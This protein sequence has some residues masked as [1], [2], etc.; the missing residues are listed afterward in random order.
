[1]NDY[2]AIRILSAGAPITGVRKCA[3]TH[4]AAT[5]QRFEIERA[6]APVL[7]ERINSETGVADII[8]APLVAM[9]KFVSAGRVD[10]ATVHAIGSVTIGV[11]VRNG[12]PEPDL[13]SLES[14]VHNVLAAD[15]VVYNVASS[16]QYVARMFAD[17]GLTD[18]IAAKTIIVP[19][20][21][22]VMQRLVENATSN[23]IGF[24]HITEIR[25]HDELGTHLVGQLPMAIGR[26]TPYAVGII[27]TASAVSGARALV[28]FMGSEEGHR[29][30]AASGVV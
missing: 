23:E 26:Q 3:E 5:G 4:A 12:V 11:V 16:G 25:R 21:V 7:N 6:T 17:L 9:E 28:D 27:A 10:A 8:I 13:S 22:A 1:M 29:I 20:G 18:K 2:P 19:N 15:A 14:F 30:F 24:A